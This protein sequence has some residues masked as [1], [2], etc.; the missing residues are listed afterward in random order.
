MSPANSLPARAMIAFIR[1]YQAFISPVLRALFGPSCR[2]EPSCSKY[3]VA[4]IQGH[5]AMRGGLLS[6]VRL[7]KCHPFH[8]G[9]IDLPPPGSHG[10]SQSPPLGSS[11]E[12]LLSEGGHPEQS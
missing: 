6:I 4:C 12:H 5:G 8:K 3:A 10:R 2:F 9:G 7:C 11:P 1:V